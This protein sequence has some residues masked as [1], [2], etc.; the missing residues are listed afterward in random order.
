M[1]RWNREDCL[2]LRNYKLS[3][4]IIS[5]RPK[6]F[7]STFFLIMGTYFWEINVKAVLLFTGK[8]D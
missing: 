8:E 4:T 7:T 3:I 2:L 6:M 5:P 1:E